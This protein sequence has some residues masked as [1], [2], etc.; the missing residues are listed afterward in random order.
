MTAVEAHDLTT[1]GG[2]KD[3]ARLIEACEIFGSYCLIG[4][5]VNCYVEPVYTDERYQ[6][7]LARSIKAE[8]LGVRVKVASG[9][10]RHTGKALGLQ[11]STATIEQENPSALP[12]PDPRNLL[13][14]CHGQTD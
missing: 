7:F 6:A 8:V 4:L 9:G 12:L 10:G 5:A 3:V 13:I 1:K 14:E 2:A 11:R